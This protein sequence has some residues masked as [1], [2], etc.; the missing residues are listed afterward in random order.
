MII[1]IELDHEP[2]EVVNPCIDNGLLVVK[3]SGNTFRFLPPLIIEKEHCDE[4]IDKLERVL[5]RG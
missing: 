1:G 4:A 2:K 3:T 5:K